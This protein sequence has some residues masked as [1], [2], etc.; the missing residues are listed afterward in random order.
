MP[1]GYAGR[2]LLR[3][4][5]P[6]ARGS[7]RRYRPRSA[8]RAAMRPTAGVVRERR[9]K[10]L[11][12]A[13]RKVALEEPIDGLEVVL[14]FRRDKRHRFAGGAGAARTADS[15]NVVV[16][17]MRQLEVDHDRQRIDVE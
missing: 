17:G 6:A 8:S 12:D 14:F 11:H 4:S 15:V 10:A 1:S 7:T 16:R 2:V 13:D 3:H 9:L 5:R